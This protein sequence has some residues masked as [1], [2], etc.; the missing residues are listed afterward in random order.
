MFRVMGKSK[1]APYAEVQAV[2]W[3]PWRAGWREHG[4]V[5][6]MLSLWVPRPAS[7]V[8]HSLVGPHNSLV[9]IPLGFG[10]DMVMVTFHTE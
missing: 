2:Q 3:S 1:E 6:V 5:S 10:H 7:G 4:R 8:C 9:H